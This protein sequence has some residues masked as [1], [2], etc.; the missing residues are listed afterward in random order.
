M[1]N[2]E[3]YSGYLGFFWTNS[4]P[5]NTSVQQC[6]LHLNFQVLKQPPT[7]LGAASLAYVALNSGNQSAKCVMIHHNI[8]PHLQFYLLTCMFDRDDKMYVC[9][10]V[11]VC[12]CQRERERERESIPVEQ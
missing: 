12:V 10:C 3:C 6:F 2:R 1:V 11:C 8:I 9:V 7:F 4:P 5:K